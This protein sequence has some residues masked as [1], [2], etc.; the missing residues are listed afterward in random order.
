[1]KRI[2]RMI[3]AEHD[4]DGSMNWRDYRGA[5][6][7]THPLVGKTCEILRKSDDERDRVFSTVMSFLSLYIC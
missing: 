5:S 1:M 4:P 3:K 6:T 2:E 7:R